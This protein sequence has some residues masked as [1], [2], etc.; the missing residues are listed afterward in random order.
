MY[1]L[2]HMHCYIL[3]YVDCTYNTIAD[4]CI[5]IEKVNYT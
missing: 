4:V 3:G 5:Q 1:L 2:E